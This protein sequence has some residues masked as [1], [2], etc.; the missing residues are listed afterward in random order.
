MGFVLQSGVEFQ[1]EVEFQLGFLS[2]LGFSLQR[3][4]DLSLFGEILHQ[5]EYGNSV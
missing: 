4:V 5:Q 3:W 2:Q 1:L